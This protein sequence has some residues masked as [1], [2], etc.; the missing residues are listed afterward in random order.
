MFEVGVSYTR[1]EIHGRVGGSVEAYL[2]NVGGRVVAAC[3]RTDTNP[4]APAVILPGIGPEIER[5]ADLLA[6]QREP[7]PTFLKRGTGAWEYVGEFVATRSSRDPVEITTHARRACRSD[8]TMVVHMAPAGPEGRDNA[9]HGSL[10][11][12]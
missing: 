12:R 1:E 11:T 4:D 3:L 10:D 7:V 2:P 5:A 6:A 8:I 9:P